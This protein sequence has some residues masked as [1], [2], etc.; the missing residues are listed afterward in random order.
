M[1]TEANRITEGMEKR[2]M[3]YSSLFDGGSFINLPLA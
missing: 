3:K 1:N 2:F